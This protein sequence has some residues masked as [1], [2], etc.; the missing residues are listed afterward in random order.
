[1]LR[2]TFG[3]WV[4]GVAAFGASGTVITLNP[5]KDATIIQ[6]NSAIANGAGLGLFAG[7]IGAG[8]GFARRGLV[9]F[10]VSSIPAGSTINSVSVVLTLTKV[11]S[12]SAPTQISLFRVTNGWSEGPS[13]AGN[14]NG[15]GSFA[16][17]GDV[18]WEHT[19]FN[20]MFWNNP[21]GDFVPTPSATQT[22][23]QS[24]VAYTWAST[25]TL[26]ADVQ[27][28]VN[29]PGTNFGWLLK[30][31]EAIATT[32]RRFA[33]REVSTVTQRPKVII[34]YTP[35]PAPSA[36]ALAPLA[37]LAACRRRRTMTQ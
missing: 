6:E 13:H 37:G 18:T 2:K 21:G 20:M 15:Q 35:V 29:N 17:A 9:Q 23:G 34:D 36:L 7:N 16:Q 5:V 31:N 24:L 4:L 28:W 14:A 22:I 1:M 26:I 33:S 8:V 19:L 10:D 30:G 25:P 3:V 11:N 32:T 27:G 12:G